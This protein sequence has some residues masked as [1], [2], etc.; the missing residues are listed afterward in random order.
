MRTLGDRPASMSTAANVIACSFACACLGSG[1]NQNVGPPAPIDFDSTAV[2]IDDD[3]APSPER[4]LVVY[5]AYWQAVAFETAVAPGSS[6]APQGTFPASDN[7]A[8]VVLA[9]G[10]DPDAGSPPT[11]FVLLQSRNGFG[12]H[13][14]DTLHI[15]VDDATFAG[16]CASGSFLTQA[17]ADFIVQ[18]I[19]TAHIFPDVWV[20][21]GY[22]A[23]TC[24]T[25]LLGDA[26]PL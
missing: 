1:C 8:Y 17:Q 11:S 14:G 16:N 3:Y 26:G 21:F 24:T 9:P 19:F 25:T 13:L 12:V 4:S 18:R 6:S 5:S 22:D 10:W 15:P 20:P 23:A 7:T 2:V